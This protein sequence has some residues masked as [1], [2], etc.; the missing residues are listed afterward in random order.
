MT[1]TPDHAGFADA[2]GRLRE[3]QGRDVTFLGPKVQTWPPDTPLDDDGQPYDPFVAPQTEAQSEAIVRCSVAFRAQGSDA[4]GEEAAGPMGW[5]DR[6]HVLLVA[7]IAS[8]GV[9]HDQF[10]LD[11]DTY[12]ITG[13]ARDAIGPVTRFLVYGRRDAA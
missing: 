3:M 12:Q 2:Q 11:G 8:E 5:M 10:R 6:Q 7:P 13:T 9:V 1:V 4:G